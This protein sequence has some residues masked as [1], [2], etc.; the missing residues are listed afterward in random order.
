MRPH[1]A[2]ILSALGLGCG[3]S[4]TSNPSNN[5]DAAPA[6]DASPAVDVPPVAVEDVPP[7]EPEDVPPVEPEDVPVVTGDRENGEPCDLDSECRSGVCANTPGVASGCAQPCG[8][9]DDCEGTT[10]VLDRARTGGR[11]VCGQVVS[12]VVEAAEACN[13]DTE[14]TWGFCE[15]GLC[16]N[17]C[18][19]DA[20]CIPGWR[21]GP[22]P[23]GPRAVQACRATPITGVTVEDFT[24]F[25]GINL[26][27]R[28]IPPVRVVA[29]PDTVSLTWVTQ[30][31]AGAN[32]YAAVTNVTDPDG[33]VQ[34]DLRTWN[35]L[36]EQ[37]VRTFPSR[38]QI[39]TATFPGRET[40]AMVPGVFT[41]SHALLND[42][43]GTPVLSRAMRALVR[44]KRAPGGL[45]ANGWT[46]RLRVIIGG[47]SGLNA[48]NAR[49]NTR[50][51]N[52]IT[53]MRTIYAGT[54]VNV[55]VDGY[56]D[57]VPAMASRFATI[58]SQAELRELFAQSAGVTPDSLVVFLV[59][60]IAT[61]AGLENAIG[62]AGG[63][64]GPPGINGTVA[65]GVVAS[66][67]NTGGRTD[68]LG[69]VLAHEVGHY[70]GL[71]HVR[72]RLDPCT[73]TGQMDC[74]I[75]GGVDNIA[76]TP[77][78]T[79]AQQYLMYWTTN[80][81]NERLSPGQGRMMRLNPMVH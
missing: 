20:Q 13:A 67:D 39:N 18:A 25:D 63:I 55:L 3:A 6:V 1:L 74:S 80:G 64:N 37:P 10:C 5:A 30:D 72:E 51:Q 73:A 59:R 14:C 12:S 17:P 61:N 79:A 76:D 33:A 27:D 46:L 19:D 44:V 81:T 29:P 23:A 26:V 49:T 43:D 2:L 47:I 16:H 69:A 36:R 15:G 7:V 8:V 62:I 24:L 35:I 53:R 58:D 41:S 65:S 45:A 75:W 21:C 28:S 60:G 9:D 71:W 56:A 48:T 50:L 38:L 78:T 70:L 4:V 22:T 31:L 11:F 68:L 66:W 52:A 42:R 77:T 40:A 57:M 54:G 34:A 32:L